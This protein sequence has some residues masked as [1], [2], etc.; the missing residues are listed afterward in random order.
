VSKIFYWPLLLLLLFVAAVYANTLA[1]SFH[2]DDL[3]SLVLNPHVRDWAN[4]P[5]FFADPSLFSADANKAM[6]RPLL[7]TSYALNYA[8]GQY[9]ST[10][11]HAVNIA[12]HMGCI[13]LV[14]ALARRFDCGRQGALFAAAFFALH[15]LAT[16]PVNY[17][18]SRSES[19]A[20]LCLLAAL[21]F[22]SGES[23]T[24][25]KG[26]SWLCYLAGLLVKSIAVALPIILVLYHLLWKRER[27]PWKRQMPYW[28]CTGMY[29]AIIIANRF[30]SSSLAK[31]PRPLGEQLLTQCKALVYYAQLIVMP[32]HLNVEHQFAVS[33][34]LWGA[35]L[36][37]VLFLVSVA[38]VVVRCRQSKWLFWMG[39]IL[40]ALLPTLVVPLNVLVN[41]HRLYMPMAALALA[42]G[43]AWPSLGDGKSNRIIYVLLALCALLI[44]QRNK[45]WS[46]ELSLWQD[47]AEKSPQM[48][49]PQV[50][51]G[52]ALRERGDYSGAKEAFEKALTLDP[53][54]RSAR[55]NLANIYLEAARRDSVRSSEYLQ[56]AE[57]Q[58]IRVLALDPTYNEALNNLGSLYLMRGDLAR[59]EELYANSLERNPNFSDAY[60][61]WGQVKALRGDF[62]AAAQLFER[63]LALV[64][65]GEMWYELGN[66]RAQLNQFPEAALAYRKA[67]ELSGNDSRALYNMA[68]VLLVSGERALASGEKKQ[69]LDL[70]REAEGLLAHLVVLDP[71]HQR[72]ASRLQQVRV[73]LQ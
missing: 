61:N 12:I 10:G 72:A 19:L 71:S 58:Y 50:Y 25:E 67:I 13:V 55:T 40:V 48:S 15:P 41:E 62:V 16:E 9:D 20:V 53:E 59:A 38:A 7:L 11:Y 35:P 27:V 29:L 8:W 2:Y 30:L 18:S 1:G 17:I 68:E 4:I 45:V 23:R 47:A 22:Y 28:V 64:D 52:N 63:G 73:R 31:S 46:D 26:L 6:Y 5:A 56:R 54:H 44:Y 33:T 66:A 24:W 21:Y 49:R 60:Y 32:T 51:L 70:W 36:L 39:W 14:W 65:D 69:A 37:A 43:C 34:S 3:H 42:A 57:Q